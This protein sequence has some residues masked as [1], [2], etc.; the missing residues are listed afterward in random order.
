[1]QTFPG[2][3]AH[4]SSSKDREVVKATQAT[5]KFVDYHQRRK[6][7]AATRHETMMPR[8]FVWGIVT[9]LA[10]LFA[11]NLAYTFKLW[12]IERIDPPLIDLEK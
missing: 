3:D 6:P 5:R 7:T 12:S 4:P 8:K 2:I 9:V 1:M 11:I 10:V